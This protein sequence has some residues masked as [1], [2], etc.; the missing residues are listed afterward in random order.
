MNNIQMS[1]AMN[2]IDIEGE[3]AW[4]LSEGLPSDVGLQIRVLI[5]ARMSKQAALAIL[6]GIVRGI[7]KT[8]FLKTATESDRKSQERMLDDKDIPF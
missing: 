3:A 8:D 7:R 2:Y 6:K 5:P 4:T 1:W